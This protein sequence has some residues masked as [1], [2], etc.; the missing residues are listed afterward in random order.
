MYLTTCRVEQKLYEGMTKK[1]QRE[2]W[3]CATNTVTHHVINVA[4][5]LNM[6]MRQN[7][8]D[9]AKTGSSTSGTSL[10]VYIKED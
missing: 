9:S 1:K 5:M 2:Y 3:K 7:C 8:N 6:R 10:T 4:K